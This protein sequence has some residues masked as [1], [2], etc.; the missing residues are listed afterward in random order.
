MIL[1]IFNYFIKNIKNIIKIINNKIILK[2]KILKIKNNFLKNTSK[3]SL[4]TFSA[5]RMYKK[6]KDTE[7]SKTQ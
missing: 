6:K 2:N 1:F 3:Q 5:L 4:T 7:S